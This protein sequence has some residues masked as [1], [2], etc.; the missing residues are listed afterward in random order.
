MKNQNR[1]VEFKLTRRSTP[2]EH[3][4][5]NNWNHSEMIKGTF[6]EWGSECEEGEETVAT[7]SIG[8]IEDE[9]GQIHTP[10]AWNV[11]FLGK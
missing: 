3:A 4:V 7:N 5:T 8:I 6:H 11:K 10:Y 9:N 1:L 2:E